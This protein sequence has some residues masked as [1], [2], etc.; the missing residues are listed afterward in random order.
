[1]MSLITEGERVREIGSTVALISMAG[2]SRGPVIVSC[3]KH[4]SR[5]WESGAKRLKHGRRIWES[6]AKVLKHG[7]RIV[8]D[9]GK[10]ERRGYD[11]HEVLN[12]IPKAGWKFYNSE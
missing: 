7:R 10:V 12:C 3:M 6:G 2:S 11:N 1:M 5:I 8:V 9:S 4:G